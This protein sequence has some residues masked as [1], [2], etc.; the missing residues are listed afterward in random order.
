M[1]NSSEILAQYILEGTPDDVIDRYNQLSDIAKRAKF[2]VLDSNIVVIDTETT[3]FSFH[4][5]ELTQIAAARMEDG[6]IVEW[7]N[8]FVNPGK[9]IPD[10]VQYLTNIHDDDVK[11]APSPDE[12]LADLVAF[13][14]DAKIIAHNAEFDKTF[15]TKHPSGYPLLTNQWIDSLDLARIALPRLKSHRLID[16]VKAFGAPISTHSADDDVADT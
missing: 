16:L 5:D 8:T 10:D 1:N 4:H 3:G 12:A 2:D 13:V 6:E 15:T 14:G 9:P 7:F 11:D